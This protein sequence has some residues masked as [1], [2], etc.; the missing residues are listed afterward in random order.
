MC[1]ANRLNC[2]WEI[3]ETVKFDP[4]RWL[5][6]LFDFSRGP[7]AVPERYAGNVW[8]FAHLTEAHGA[9]LPQ[10]EQVSCPAQ[11]TQ[12]TAQALLCRPFR[13]LP[14]QTGT[15]I[16]MVRLTRQE[17]RK[18]KCSLGSANPL[19]CLRSGDKN[20]LEGQINQK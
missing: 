16:E 19:C 6:L 1:A 4:G 9:A 3:H 12:P 5:Q 14:V 20:E 8:G 18:R 2:Q 13:K 10:Q 15:T 11:T 17:M 7:T